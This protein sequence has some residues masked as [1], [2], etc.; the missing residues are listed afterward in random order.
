M[1]SARARTC[2][3]RYREFA[4]RLPILRP[5]P[6]WPNTVRPSFPVKA[7][8]SALNP[9]SHLKLT[10]EAASRFQSATGWVCAPMRAGSSHSADTLRSTGVFHRAFRLMSG[11]ERSVRGV[12][13]SH[14]QAAI[15]DGSAD[16]ATHRL[17]R[18]TQ[19]V[20]RDAPSRRLQ[21]RSSQPPQSD[22][23]RVGSAIGGADHRS[24]SQAQLAATSRDDDGRSCLFR[25]TAAAE[26][27]RART[28]R[29]E[30][31]KKTK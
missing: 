19:R 2:C 22:L 16:A 1:H 15:S 4:E 3:M 17:A 24:R 23:R 29:A 21:A 28:D 30:T 27:E 14:R 18:A 11:D 10:P 7:P 5:A 26:E 25:P 6:G 20:R 31:T 13:E 8:C 12:P 9:G